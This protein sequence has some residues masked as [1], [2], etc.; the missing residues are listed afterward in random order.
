VSHLRDSRF[1]SRFCSAGFVQFLPQLPHLRLNV[2]LLRLIGNL[3]RIIG[4]LV[5]R[6]SVPLALS[7]LALPPHLPRNRRKVQFPLKYAPMTD[8][9]FGKP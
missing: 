9:E 7:I 1:C 8:Y 5:L 4:P 2:N 3:L 6:G